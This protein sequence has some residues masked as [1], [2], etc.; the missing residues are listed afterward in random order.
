M[1]AQGQK[2]NHHSWVIMPNHVHLL[3][4]PLIELEQLLKI[5]KEVSARRIGKGSIWQANYRDTLIR[6][7]EHFTKVVRYI[8]HNPDKLPKNDFTLWE[9]ERAIAIPEQ[10]HFCP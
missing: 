5:W 6:D 2:V 8:R 1:R 9:G 7:S 3:F 10:G 4:E